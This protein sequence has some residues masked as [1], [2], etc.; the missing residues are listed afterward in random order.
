MT[1]T[2]EKGEAG[3]KVGFNDVLWS[4]SLSSPISEEIQG[5][6]LDFKTFFLLTIKPSGNVHL[7]LVN[8]LAN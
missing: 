1:K 8:L 7:L 6:S 5:F 4:K 3:E 2:V